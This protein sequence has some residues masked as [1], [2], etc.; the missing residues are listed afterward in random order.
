MDI[1][2]TLRAVDFSQVTDIQEPLWRK[3]KENRQA[4]AIL[5]LRKG[6]V[7]LSYDDLDQVAAAGT[8]PYNTEKHK[9]D[10]Q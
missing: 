6:I 10:A 5:P 1:E 7:E 4:E 2:K 3:I 8:M 9:E